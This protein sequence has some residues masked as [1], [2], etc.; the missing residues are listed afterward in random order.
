MTCIGPFW[1]LFLRFFSSPIIPGLC[2]SARLGSFNILK[3]ISPPIF[4]RPKILFENI[5][6]QHFFKNYRKCLKNFHLFLDEKMKILT[7]PGNPQ[8]R[9]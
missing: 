9:P 5:F 7:L 8:P 1:G 4:A 6:F 3:N 2:D